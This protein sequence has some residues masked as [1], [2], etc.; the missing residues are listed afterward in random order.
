MKILLIAPKS[1]LGI[2]LQT[3]KYFQQMSIIKN[4]QIDWIGSDRLI[5][6]RNNIEKE[7]RSII[8]DINFNNYDLI[9]FHFGKLEL[10]QFLPYILKDKKDTLPPCVLSVHSLYFD[11]FERTID[12]GDINFSEEINKNIKNFFDGY[13]YYGS[14]AK[15]YFGKDG[16]MVFIHEQHSDCKINND[17][18]INFLKEFCLGE[19]INKKIFTMIGYESP[20]KDSNSII[21]ALEILEES[22]CFIF[23]GYGWYKKL[24]FR[25]KVIGKSTIVVIDRNLNE[26]EMRFFLKISYCGCL[27]YNNHKSFQGSG[28]LPN[29]IYNNIPVIVSNIANLSEMSNGFGLIIQCNNH[30]ILSNTISKMLDSKV[31]NGFLK[32][33]RKRKYIFSRK[34]HVK[35]CLN[36]F[37]KII[38]GRLS[39]NNLL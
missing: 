5:F 35:K 33:I 18:Y 38:K 17:D 3:K 27:Y 11:L 4:L 34:Y 24:G 26:K 13:I 16:E 7:A 20:W 39:Y 21:K 14:Y 23:A 1:D 15:K 8:K 25:N 37:R 19:Y 22:I 28:V 32:N 30:E 2:G 12:G 31:Y 6:D 10:E 9:N 29:Y 36:Y